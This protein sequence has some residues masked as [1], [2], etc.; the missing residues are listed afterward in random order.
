MARIDF[1]IA[2]SGTV[3]LLHPLTRAAHTWIAE[4]LPANAM[5]L[6]AAVVIEWRYI[7]DI[8]GGTIGDGLQVR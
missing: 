8:V 7:G 4:H 2:G 5:R 6:G 1:E 3:Y